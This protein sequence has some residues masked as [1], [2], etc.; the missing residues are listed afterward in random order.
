MRPPPPG[1]VIALGSWLLAGAGLLLAT[2]LLHGSDAV[3]LRLLASMAAV[4]LPVLVL[5]PAVGRRP[6][7]L[8]PAHPGWLLAGLVLGPLSYAVSVACHLGLVAIFGRPDQREV[9]VAIAG[10]RQAYGLPLLFLL[11]AVLPGLVEEALFRG[12]VLRGLRRHLPAAASVL[13]AA[14]LFALLHLDRWRFLPQFALG[15]ICGMLALRSGSCW[16]AVLVHAGHNATVLALLALTTR[17]PP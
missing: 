12:P 5:L 4:A 15:V 10:I 13:L 16:P 3:V 11:A 2:A 6:L 8:G 9:E 14:L 17:T 7:G 1:Y